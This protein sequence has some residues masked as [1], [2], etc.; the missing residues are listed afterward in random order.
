MEHLTLARLGLLV[1]A[2]G[3]R[4]RSK[5]EG[6]SQIVKNCA[7]C[8]GLGIYAILLELRIKS[9]EEIS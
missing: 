3:Q 7:L 9:L 2:I 4:S 5:D 6:Q 1:E 8:S